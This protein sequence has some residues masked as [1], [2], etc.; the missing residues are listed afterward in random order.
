MGFYENGLLGKASGKVGHLVYYTRK[1][2]KVVRTIGENLV[3][4]TDAQ[5]AC[6]MQMGIASKFARTLK[7]FTQVGFALEAER[8]NKVVNNVANSAIKLYSLKGVYP[9]IEIDFTKLVLSRGD[10]AIAVSPEV[11]IAE[12]GLVF[13]W[14]NGPEMEWPDSTDQV[15]LLTYFPKDG[16]SI[17]RL[18]G[19]ERITGT[20]LLEVSAPLLGKP[21]EAYISFISADRKRISDSVHVGSL[22]S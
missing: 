16:K 22:N 20:A 12:N 8:E 21:M 3:P 15:M 14:S 18:F 11:A 1:G 6:R 7:G 19:P 17:Y 4:P 10:L 2:K 13:S 9:N 5:L